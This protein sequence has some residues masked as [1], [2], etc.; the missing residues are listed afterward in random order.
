MEKESKNIVLIGMPGCGKTSIGKNLA[1]QLKMNFID[2]DEYIE[3]KMQISIPEIFKQGEE[4]FRK[5]ETRC[6]EELSKLSS[7][8]ISTG[9]GVVKSPLNIEFL[10]ENGII[11][12]INRPLENIVNDIDIGVRPLLADGKEKI[13]KLYQDRIGLYNKYKDY[14]I[15]NDS[16]L[17]NVMEKM[18]EISQKIS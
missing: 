5:I 4:H 14:E 7:T 2:V 15:I 12:F 17:E 13:F 10:K 8:I 1:E 16:S 18:S 11:I 6:I 3:Q 9:G